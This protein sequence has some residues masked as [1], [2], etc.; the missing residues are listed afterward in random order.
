MANS[1]RA[2]EAKPPTKGGQR[3]IGLPS[4]TSMMPRSAAPAMVPT[5]ARIGKKVGASGASKNIWEFMQFSTPASSVI[6]KASSI[7]WEWA[8]RSWFICSALPLNV[9][10]EAT[11]AAL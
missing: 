8:S 7:P 3:R 4:K 9:V 6:P 11:S 2:M 10:Y 5:V 1:E